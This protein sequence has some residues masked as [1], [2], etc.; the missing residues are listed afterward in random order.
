MK[1]DKEA[2]E[3]IASLTRLELSEPEKAMYAEQLSAIL[4]YIERLSEVNT[5]STRETS[6]VTG[7][8]DIV[9]EDKAK[10][11]PAEVK[12]RILNQFPEKENNLLKVKAVFG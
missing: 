4:D 11:C 8:E 5:D 6:Q 7:L 2:I 3:N 9:R 1:L 10:D 12:K